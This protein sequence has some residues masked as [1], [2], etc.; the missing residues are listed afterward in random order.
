MNRIPL[1]LLILLCF[2]ML[3]A[4]NAAPAGAQGI[5]LSAAD[6]R[7]AVETW[8]RKVPVEGRPDAVVADLEP[9]QEDG[10]TVAYIAHL[11]GG[12]FC[13]AGADTSVLP[14][15]FYSPQGSYDPANPEYHAILREIAARRQM[16]REALAGTAPLSPALQSALQDR[17]AYWQELIA[18]RAPARPAPDATTM[19]Q[20]SYLLLPL[21]ARWHQGAPYFDQLPVLTSGSSEHVLVGC[22]ATATAQIMYYWKWPPSGVGSHCINYAYRW[23]SGWDSVSLTTS[24]S[25]P[26]DYA[27]RLR[28]DADTH[29]LQM[30]GYWDG[31]IYTAAQNLYPS[32]PDYQAALATLWSHMTQASKT[33]CADFGN[34]TY[35]WGI[36][37]DTNS[38]PPDAAGNE[39]AQISAHAAIGVDSSLGLWSTNSYFGNDVH[40]LKTYFRYDPDALYTAPPSAGGAGADINSLTTE[41]TWG[42]LAGLGG[43]NAAGA[44][45]AWVIDGYDKSG[46]PNRLFH[47]NLGWGGDSNGWYTLDTAPLPLDHDMMTRIAPTTVK[48]VTAPAGSSGDGSPNSPYTGIERAVTVAPDGSTLMLQAGSEYNFAGALVIN[49]PLTL[50]GFGATI[51]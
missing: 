20:P 31:S 16:A 23:R 15:Y 5:A 18:G 6:V 2:L 45:H 4:S 7:A 11:A 12:G 41:I 43:S 39:A 3:L 47:M 48:F 28:Y 26:S 10:E 9:Y 35:N 46:D 34:T 27:G 42:R 32:R 33:S 14:V 30:N 13:L 51:R 44:G 50:N 29:T 1:R 21:T 22:N 37:R 40:G 17:A 24:V 38:E 25:I 36:M 49:R 8:V 19:A